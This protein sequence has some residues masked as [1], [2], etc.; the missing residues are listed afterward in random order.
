MVRI[1]VA[2]RRPC[3]AEALATSSYG[4]NF[5]QPLSADTFVSA[6]VS[7]VLPWSTWPMVPTLTCGFFLRN[8]SFAMIVLLAGSASLVPRPPSEG[9][10]LL[11]HSESLCNELRRDVLRHRRVMVE[12]HGVDGP[13]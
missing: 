2:S 10:G 11:R 6:A 9:A 8:F 5:D 12:L 13:A 4:T 7:V 3:A 1:F